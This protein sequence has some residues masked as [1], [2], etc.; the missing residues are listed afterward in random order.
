MVEWSAEWMIE[1]VDCI[2]LHAENIRCKRR[3]WTSTQKKDGLH[4][5]ART[6]RLTHFIDVDGFGISVEVPGWRWRKWNGEETGCREQ[7]ETS[8]ISRLPQAGMWWECA[9]AC[10][11]KNKVWHDM[12][13]FFKR[14]DVLS[15]LEG[16]PAVWRQHYFFHLASF[17][18]RQYKAFFTQHDD[19][20][21]RK[22]A[23]CPRHSY[24]STFWSYFIFQAYI[25]CPA[26]CPFPSH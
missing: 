5:H 16:S 4:A 13:C 11:W 18:A 3:S 10:R 25:A 9:M 20:R 8:I 17:D 19:L 14:E 12:V 22:S 23:V 15:E 6:S 24:V 7:R 21:M 1:W 2:Y 26:W